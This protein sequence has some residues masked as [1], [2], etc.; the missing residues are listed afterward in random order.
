MYLLYKGFRNERLEAFDCNR[1][2]T[3]NTDITHTK[4]DFSSSISLLL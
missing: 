2:I 4:R 3:E 1:Y